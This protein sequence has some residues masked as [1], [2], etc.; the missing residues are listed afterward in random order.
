MLS[1][2]QVD[3][4]RKRILGQLNNT[5]MKLNMNE[6]YYIFSTYL[7]FNRN[8]ISPV[9]SWFASLTTFG[10]GW[11]DFH[12]SFPWDYNVSE[13]PMPF[14]LTSILIRFCAKIGLAYDLKTTTPDMVCTYYLIILINK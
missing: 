7:S 2:W 6:L 14:D 13:L 5:Y 10:E 3:L 11:H 1:T 8:I 4:I 12:H 9:K